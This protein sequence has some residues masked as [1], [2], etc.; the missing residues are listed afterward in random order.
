MDRDSKLLII[1]FIILCF[2]DVIDYI[3]NIYESEILY[4]GTYVVWL[5]AL[6]LFVFGIYK[7][8]KNKKKR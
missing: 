1:A 2:G 8:I 5:L 7:S 3:S 6:G 4:Y